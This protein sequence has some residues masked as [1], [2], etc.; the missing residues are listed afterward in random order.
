MAHASFGRQGFARELIAATLIIGFAVVWRTWTGPSPTTAAPPASASATPA[1]PKPMALVNGAEISAEELSAECLARHGS[2]VLETLVNRRIIEQ[3][4]RGKGIAVTRQD[5]DAE[6]D[7]LAKRFSVPRDQWLELIQKERGIAPEQYATDIV[8][9]MLALRALAQGEGEPTEAEIQQA[10]ENRFGPAVKARILVSRTRGEAESLR[11]QALAAPD[12]FGS[13]ARQH[14]VDVGSASANGWVQPIRLHSG[15]PAFD[16]A[17]FA[18]EPGEISPVVQVADQFIVIKCEG[19]LP[20]AEASPADVRPHLAAEI[21]ERKSRQASNDVF[22]RLQDAS[23]IENVM[24]DPA[25]AAAQPDIAAIVNGEPVRLDEVRSV[26]V[27]RHGGEVLEILIT[28]ALIRQ[29]LAKQQLQ[30]VQADLDAEVDRAAAQM[31]FQKPDGAPDREAWLARVTKEEKIPLRHYLEDVVWPTVALK[32][33][34]GGVPVHKEDLDK[35]FAATFGPR[36]RCR[37][38]VLDNQRRA[39][40]VWQLARQNPTAEAIGGLAETYSVDPTT[41]ALRGEVPPIQRYGGQPTLEREVF[42]LQPGE[43]SGVVQIA[44][45]F[46]VIFCEGFTEPAKVAFDEVR[47]ELYD[48]IFEKKQRV[49]MARYFTHLRGAAAIDNFLAGTSQAP[50]KGGSGRGMPDLTPGANVPQAVADDLTRPRTG[51]RRAAAAPQGVVP[52]THLAP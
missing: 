38:I 32:K 26:A 49:E 1:A 10:F 42:G 12:Q 37:I 28:R 24:N 7:T 22:R 46:M 40:E 30:I 5:V 20:A 23:R 19:R 11:E 33:L 35:A 9:P 25:R 44:D 45:R 13:L 48:D 21:R 8:W 4:C 2:S 15:D 51:S 16:R 27:D 39:Q 31:G 6:I 52:A 18:L 14:S 41:R 17:A 50:A 36:A 3:A 34:V 29:A 47:T 43:L